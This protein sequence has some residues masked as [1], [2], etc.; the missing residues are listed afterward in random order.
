MSWNPP[1][2]HNR[3]RG[4]QDHSR[5]TLRGEQKSCCLRSSAAR[6]RISIPMCGHGTYGPGSASLSGC[7]GLNLILYSIHRTGIDRRWAISQSNTQPVM[8]RAPLTAR[9]SSLRCVS[10]AEHHTAKQYKKRS[11]QNSGSIS[12]EVIY[13]RTLARTYWRYKVFEKLL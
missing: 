4:Q 3:I 9:S 11:G 2:R 12:Q 6:W 8:N 1:V 13:H 5:G 7:I 10:A